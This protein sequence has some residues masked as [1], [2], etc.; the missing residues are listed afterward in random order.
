MPNLRAPVPC[1]AALLL[2][3]CATSTPVAISPLQD[4]P[5]ADAAAG[6]DWEFQ[7]KP[8]LLLVTIDGDAE[9]RRVTNVPVEVD[10]SDVLDTL[11]MGGMLH[12][13]A[14]HKSGWG[15][16]LDYAFMELG[17]DR[18]GRAGIVL[19]AEVRQ[20]IFEG[21]ASHR[22]RLKGG[23]VLDA[24]AGV[25][26]W[27]NNIDLRLSPGGTQRKRSIDW[28]DPVIGAQ[29]AAPFAK[30]WSVLARGDIGGFGL[31]SDF[32]WSVMGGVQ[33]RVNQRFAVELQYRA[34]GVDYQEGSG[35]SFFKYDT[36]THGPLLGF[37]FDF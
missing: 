1:F 23:T 24:F 12:G 15:F 2:A 6:K 21:L 35:A 31:E 20:A 8:Y 17:A 32:T 37:A 34:L 9:V 5:A 10:F 14:H 4:R 28:F 26:W 27:D 19:D 29:V 36:I 25:R 3:G 11:D 22:F 16:I 18:V 13:E 7:V 30:N 33:Y